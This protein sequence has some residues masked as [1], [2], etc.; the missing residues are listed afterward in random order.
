MDISNNVQI[1]EWRQSVE[2]YEVSN[3]GN[4]RRVLLRDKYKMI[5]G[6]IVRNGYRYF[7]L[8]RNGKRINHFFHTLVAL[9]FLGERPQGYEIDH[10]DRNK[11]N[12]AASNLRY[13]S[14]SDNMKNCHT[15]LSHI[16]ETDP[17]KRRKIVKREWNSKNRERVKLYQEIYESAQKLKDNIKKYTRLYN[18]KGPTIG[19]NALLA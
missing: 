3:L 16:E 10:I 5:R 14:H 4:V 17:I 11:L 6:S 1:E 9:A 8:Q 13:C 2:D 15:Y 12:N 19:L 18:T 7:Q